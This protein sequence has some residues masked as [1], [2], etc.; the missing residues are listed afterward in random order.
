MGQTIVSQVI[1]GLTAAEIRA[2]EAYPGGRIPALTGPVAAVRLGKVDRAV[3]ST[4]VLVTVMSPAA[5]GGTACETA[6]LQAVAAMEDLEGVCVKDVCKFDE[7]ADVF[8]IE[9]QAV[10]Q[11][12]AQAEDFTPGP[13]FSVT[14][15][16]QP[17]TAVVSFSSQ[18]KVEGDITDISSAK[19]EF[20]M[21]ELLGP[22]YSEPP[23]PAEPFLLVLTRETGE[24]RF[25]NC[26]WLSVKR[27]ETL[28]GIY[29]TR[30]GLAQTKGSMGIL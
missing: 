22:G 18:R 14:I 3:R 8:Y 21:E 29:Q 1:D 17:M 20:T 12:V 19:W 9:I 13:G 10:F 26:T 24:E 16:E 11:G 27:E 30:T 15:G 25:V 28:R 6:A 5:S 7:M 2:D 23:D 4:T